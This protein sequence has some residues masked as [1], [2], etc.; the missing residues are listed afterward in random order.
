MKS[1]VA[2]DPGS[3]GF[4][5]LLKQDGSR[6]YFSIVEHDML[7]I[8][9]WLA[10]VRKE[11]VELVAVMEEVHAIFGSSAAGTFSFGEIFGL[12]KGL[13]IGM[14][15]PYHL[16]PPKKWQEEIWIN[17]DKVWTTSTCKQ[18][19]KQTKRV[20]TKATSFNAAKRLFPS[21]DLRRS[22]A[23]K[24]LDDNKCDALLLSEYARRKNL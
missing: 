24:K 14:E 17:D 11:E 8:G 9:R 1:I 6:E 16:V 5:A 3:K 22:P 15:I 10:K 2:I 13:L 7:D 19:G 23:C 20:D 18:T 12:L 21:E 4:L